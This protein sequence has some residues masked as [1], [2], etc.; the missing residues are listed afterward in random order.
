MAYHL[1][2]N[3]A[4]LPQGA[5]RT[6]SS[7]A[8]IHVSASAQQAPGALQCCPVCGQPYTAES[9]SAL[10]S[11]QATFSAERLVLRCAEC[12]TYAVGLLNAQDEAN[13]EPQP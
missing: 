13:G 4:D 7:A 6:H 10:S 1:A 12:G 9:L 2:S 11:Q 5:R 8:L 3:G